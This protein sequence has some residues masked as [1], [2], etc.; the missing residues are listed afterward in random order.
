MSVKLLTWL[1]TYIVIIL[2]EL[3]DK[4]QL[5]VLLFTSNNPRQRWMIFFASAC[6]LTLCVLIEVTVGVA[7]ARYI[8]PATINRVAGIIF[9]GL[10]L[11]A[12]YQ[13]IIECKVPTVPAESIEL[14]KQHG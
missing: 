6:A 4:T 14:A 2:C 12:L 3:G 5:A 10:G 7:L 9:L 1:T 13:V 8:T 11:A